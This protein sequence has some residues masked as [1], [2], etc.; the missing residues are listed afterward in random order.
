MSSVKQ[1]PVSG[2]VAFGPRSLLAVGTA[3]GS[4]DHD[5]PHDSQLEV[6]FNLTYPDAR[7]PFI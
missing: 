3:A 6:S 2:V 1:A 7:A 4:I 5:F